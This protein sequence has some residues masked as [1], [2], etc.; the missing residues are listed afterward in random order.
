M[1]WD[2]TKICREIIYQASNV[3]KDWIADQC[4]KYQLQEV[5]SGFINKA[6]VVV[7]NSYVS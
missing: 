2:T 4:C 1:A 7:N 5:D 3:V 6:G